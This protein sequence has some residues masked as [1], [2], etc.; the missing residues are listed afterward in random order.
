MSNSP[1]E[2]YDPR[3][4]DEDASTPNSDPPD[5]AEAQLSPISPSAH[6]TPQRESNLHREKGK[7]GAIRTNLSQRS[8][9]EL[10]DC[11][12]WISENWTL[13]KWRPAIRCAVTE[14]ASLLL[15]VINPSLRAMGQ[16][17]FLILIAGMLSPP[18]DPFVTNTEREVI[19]LLCVLV[20]W[21]WASLGIKL[22]SL[23]RT[24]TDHSATIQDIFSGVYIEAAPSVI[25]ALFLFFGSAFFLYVKV[26]QGPGPFA[27]ATI[28]ACI[29]LDMALTTSALYP[30]AYYKIGQS[31]VI[32]LACH[33]ALVIVSSVLIFPTSVAAQHTIRLRAVIG[34]L[35]ATF[36]QHL[37]LLGIPTTSPEF[38]PKD[39]RVSASKAESALGP[40]AA[41]ARLLRRDISWARF[42]GKDIDGMREKVQHLVMRAHGMN[43]Y[44]S[45][46]DPTRERF[47][48][49]PA[50]SHLA[51]PAVGTPNTSRPS[52]PTRTEG[53]QSVSPAWSRSTDGCVPAEADQHGGRPAS[54]RR[55]HFDVDHPSHSVKS[56]LHGTLF[57]RHH[58]RHSHISS[59]S[60]VHHHHHHHHHDNLREQVVGVFESQR[61]LDLESHHFAHPQAAHYTERTATLLRQSCEPLLR[62]CHLG[63]GELDSW[64][65]TSRHKRW[66]FWWGGNKR[67]SIQHERLHALNEACDEL[68]RARLAFDYDCN[69]Y[70]VLEPYREAFSDKHEGCMTG[71]DIPSHRFLF[72]A[73]TYQYHLMQFSIT[74]IST[75]EYITNLENE[76]MKTRIWLPLVSFHDFFLW[77]IWDHSVNL[78]QE[79]DENPNV[80][81]GKEGL[82]GDLGEAQQRDPDALPP[83]NLFEVIMDVLY[84]AFRGISRGNQLF[85][86]KAGILTT[87]LSIPSFITS[88]A[89]FAYGERFSWAIFMGQLTLGR[90]RGDTTFA[91]VARIVSTF[92][93]GLTGA[94]IWYISTG[95]GQGNP[96][97]LALTCAIAFPFFFYGRLYWP[98]PQLSNMI[99]F[100]TV[101]LVVGYSWQNTHYHVGRFL[102]YGINLAWRRFVLVCGGYLQHCNIF[103]FLPPS[104]TLRSYQRQSLATTASGI[105]SAYCLI[106][107]YATSPHIEDPQHV[108][109]DLIAI[110]L[111]LKRSIVLSANIIY[112][113]SLRGRWPAERYQKI[114]EIQLEIAYFL[115]H[116]VSV[117]QQLE[118]A[119]TRAFLRRTRFVDPDF[120]GDVLAVISMIST[121]LRTGTPLPQITPC[122]L[123]DRFML[124]H[125]G[126]NVMRNEDDD[127]Y[128][129]PR[130][131]SMD[132]LEN[133]QYMCYCVGVSTSFGIVTRFDRLMHATKELVGEQYHIHGVGHI[134]KVG[135]TTEVSFGP[136]SL[137]PIHDA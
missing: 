44:F 19:I 98:G 110:R 111:K 105:G 39:V 37:A 13:S 128:G 84:H 133:E 49:T 50:L 28:L 36:H 127:D 112:E 107:S 80:V 93:G 12:R 62:A 126:L 7:G 43:V 89:S 46:I 20:A 71:G 42:S 91:L 27:V 90:F 9:F 72:H 103:S 73:Y 134:S 55:P 77:S 32:P 113:F 69:R 51:S 64:L 56:Y 35:G 60:G 48:V 102:Y 119:W 121:A 29:C 54:Q 66:V 67:S 11:L 17:S 82:S 74:L 132:V 45:L 94:A 47:P 22:A 14:W 40:L 95:S 75:L 58:L 3:I 21:G 26:Q 125:H 59:F 131:M 31:V 61:Y 86:I 104:T 88:S 18:S 52:S 78:E 8:I 23:A 41:S 92:A 33:S 1:K 38:S 63:L 65:R 99:F 101:A 130:T 24:H 137:R 106:V 129:L 83:E 136:N 6:S 2:N 122:P 79:D 109:Q 81:Q 15:L 116:L 124:Y 114:L 85:A 53:P 135:S 30:Y 115:S 34:P 96:Y 123:L 68:A 120:Q 108:I 87:L 57:R 25:N 100:T 4:G 16:A 70:M 117:L 118:P 76:R 5:H 97:G 10:P